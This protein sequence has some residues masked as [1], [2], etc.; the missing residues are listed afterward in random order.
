MDD[1]EQNIFSPYS[2][3]STSPISSTVSPVVLDETKTTRKILRP[4]VVKNAKNP[5]ASLSVEIIHERA[6]KNGYEA[7]EP[8]DLR[9]LKSG[10][11]LSLSL[12]SKE[13]LSLHRE[14][15]K[16]YALS[17]KFGVKYGKKHYITLE[18]S[19]DEALSDTDE[20]NLSQLLKKCRHSPGLA[21]KLATVNPKLIEAAHHYTLLQKKH[22][23]I[24]RFKVMLNE[25]CKEQEWQSFFE[26]HDWI[27]GGVYEIQFLGKL[28]GQPTIAGANV[29][30]LSEKKSDFLLCSQGH[31]RFTAIAEIKKPQT[32]LLK[33]TPYRQGVYHPSE[34]LN[35]GLAQLRTY[36]RKWQV[37]GSRTEANKDLLEGQGI[38]TIQPRGVLIVGRLDQ[39]KESREKRDAFELFRQN[40]KDVH[41]VTFDEVYYR[42]QHLLGIDE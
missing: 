24:A 33:P 6:G 10:E 4:T 38:Y 17:T 15:S 1:S 42:A 11:S 5:E 32:D 8:P 26:E 13:T 31:V 35:G 22:E 41:I 23:G 16:L 28:T 18:L 27:L 2:S 25:Q 12:S 40:Q 19:G 36:M 30:G 29:F 14:L 39:I 7:I 37:E 20:K 34:E 9:T 3:E 21:E